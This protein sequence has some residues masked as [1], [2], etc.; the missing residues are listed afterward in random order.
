M[1]EPTLADTNE[2]VGLYA[3]S[4]VIDYFSDQVLA[5]RAAAKTNPRIDAWNEAGGECQSWDIGS[6]TARC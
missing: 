3:I 1:P 2:S 5:T 6:E 4:A